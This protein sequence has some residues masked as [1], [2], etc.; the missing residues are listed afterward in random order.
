MLGTPQIDETRQ[1]PVAAKGLDKSCL[2]D[3]RAP[4]VT[5]TMVYRHADNRYY[6]ITVE[7]RKTVGRIEFYACSIL[8]YPPAKDEE[9]IAIWVQEDF[10]TSNAYLPREEP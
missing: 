4:I 1:L 9:Q 3:G 5:T 6:D 2:I 7:G 8:D 10:S